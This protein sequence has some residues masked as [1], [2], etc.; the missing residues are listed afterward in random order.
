MY[1]RDATGPISMN[2]YSTKGKRMKKNRLF[3]GVLIVAALVVGFAGTSLAGENWKEE[4]VQ[5]FAEIGMKPGD[6]ID[7]SNW[8]KAEKVLPSGVIEWVK[9]GEEVITI[10]ELKYDFAPDAEW[11][12]ASAKN[13]GK[14][15]LDDKKEVIEKSTGKYP[16][17]L[18]GDVFPTID[19]KNDPDAGIKFV[20]N[21]IAARGRLGNLNTYVTTE[22][23]GADGLE[24]MAV[25]N[26]IDSYFW[27][28]PDGEIPNRKEYNQ[29]SLYKFVEPYD[30]SGL[31]SLTI[32]SLSPEPDQVY[33]YIPSIRRVKKLS[34][35]NRS[36]PYAGSDFVVDDS[37]GWAGKNGSMKWSVLNEMVVLVQLPDWQAEKPIEAVKQA[38]GAFETNSPK[39]LSGYEAPGGKMSAWNKVG[40]VWVPRKVFV[41]EAIALDPYYSYGKSIYHIDPD[42]GFVHKAIYDRAGEYWKT[43][44]ISP[45]C[46]DWKDG[47]KFVR[48]TTTGYVTGYVVVDEKTHHASVCACTGMN[49]NVSLNPK[50]MDPTIKQGMFDH[51]Y[52][53][54]WSR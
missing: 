45:S 10:G 4:Q 11:K 31:A 18:Y 39:F 29:Q 53:N 13:E 16:L 2:N 50:F 12:I 41:V 7:S 8:Q 22:W 47:G 5:M 28:R 33:S 3:I 23:V 52:L 21:I 32:R 49:K 43:M 40:A 15:T 37:F 48:R 30:I 36:D 25:S 35:A 20:H 44:I 6:V 51:N 9:R 38:D 17:Y 46:F 34:G 54:T 14:Y 19:M 26:Y 27:N 24:R 1:E 42:M